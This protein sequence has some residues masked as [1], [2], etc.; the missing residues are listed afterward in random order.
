MLPCVLAPLGR[1][2]D[3]L[4]LEE[5]LSAIGLGC[6]LP[7]QFTKAFRERWKKQ[8]EEE[9]IRGTGLRADDA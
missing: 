2:D 9:R 1:S 3:G 4:S 8:G 5:V 6:V 7:P